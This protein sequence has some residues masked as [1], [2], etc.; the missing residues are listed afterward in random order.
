M[1]RKHSNYRAAT[2]RTCRPPLHRARP[3]WA[4]QQLP[5]VTAQTLTTT[6]RTNLEAKNVNFLSTL[7]GVNITRYG[8]ACG[9]DYIDIMR[10]TDWLAAR[11]QERVYTLLLNNDKLPYTKS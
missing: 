2:P 4:Y 3:I 11:I 1:P 5:S 8:I 7:A 6:E 10:G 9:G